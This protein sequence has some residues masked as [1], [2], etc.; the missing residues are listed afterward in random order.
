M[1]RTRPS[2]PERGRHWPARMT[3]L[4]LCLPAAVASAAYQEAPELSARVQQRELPSIEARLPLR[5]LVIQPASGFGRYGGTWQLATVETNDP[6]F[7]FR[8]LGYE[9]LVRWDPQWRRVVPGVAER[10]SVSADARRYT[11]HLRPGLRW[12]DGTPF[13]AADVLF[14]R[15]HVLT[16]TNAR[17]QLVS[18]LA[19][20]GMLPKVASA[21]A[22]EVSFEFAGPNLMFLQWLATPDGCG[23]VTHPRHALARCFPALNPGA[24]ADARAQGMDSAWNWYQVL[25]LS[26]YLGEGP[27][28]RRPT[29]DAWMAGP[30]G[31]DAGGRF[32]LAAR[33]NPYYWKVD[34]NGRQLPYIDAVRVITVPAAADVLA[35][36]L[37]G[38][39]HMQDHYLGTRDQRAAL[40]AAQ[41]AGKVRL[42]R[43]VPSHSNLAAISLNLTHRDPDLRAF[44]G[45]REVRIAL[46]HA[47]NRERLIREDLG[48]DTPPY[49]VAPRPESAYFHERL[50]RQHLRWDVGEARRLLQAAGYVADE[51]GVL[52][53]RAGRSISFAIQIAGGV[54]ADGG[55]VAAGVAR[56]WKALGLDVRVESYSQGEWYAR[57]ERNL[58]DVVIWSGDGGID[59][60][61]EPRYYAP[62]TVESNYAIP[63]A[64]WHVDPQAPGAEEPPP[65][66]RA[67]LGQYR[68]LLAAPDEA[69]QRVRWNQLA[70]MT[71]NEFLVLGI[72]LSP[73]G[74]GVLHPRLRN[75]PDSIF[76][77]WNYPQPGPANPCQFSFAE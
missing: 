9:P 36:A 39:L 11:F 14:W 43:R 21:E 1:N 74:A 57:K 68:A 47:L 44:F 58:H 34:S 61:L 30:A 55:H 67:L 26:P 25:W 33:R 18:W 62:V 24:E 70:D 45:R 63:W 49:Q 59:P 22:H 40:Q 75:V 32:T 52:R 3:L 41:A 28:E 15:E 8:N 35:L 19:P 72:G 66:I 56:D 7:V 71:A 6:G 60:L 76:Q 38:E 31:P 10:W 53:S 51:A 16:H 13:T 64:R 73:A 69:T 50:A 27:R 37:A 20:D 77:A 17:S 46:S 29:L 2:L 65:N 48:I 42:S 4:M 23:P 5:P 12:S 54:G